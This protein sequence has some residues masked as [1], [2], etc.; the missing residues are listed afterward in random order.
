V[1]PTAAEPNE[2]PSYRALF[3]VPAIGRVLLGIVIARTAATMS[4]VVLVL[5]TLTYFRSP[6]LAGAVTFISIAPGLL[7]APLAGAL[8][9]RHGRARLVLVDYLVAA[10]ACVVIAVLAMAGTLTAPLLLL[11]AACNGLAW[12][13]STSG[14]RSLLPMLVP[15]PL[16]ERANAIDSNGYVIATLIGPPVAGAM[17]AV[18]GGPTA[19]AI[20]G[21]VYAA[22]AISMVGIPDPRTPFES[23]GRLL[24]DALDGLRYVARN[25]TLLALAASVS[26]WN[27][28]GGMLQI[29]VPV[30]LI[31][32]LGEGPAVVGLAWAT[33]GLAGLVAALF[34]GR[35]DSRGREKRMIIWPL[36]G[37]SVAMLLLLVHAQLWTIVIV[38]AFIGLFN[39]PMDVA[40]FTIRQRRTDPAWMGR[41]FAISMALNFAG[42][43]LGSAI[44][45]LL[46]TR[47]VELTV[48]IAAATALLAAI[49]AW[50]LIP[51]RD[52]PVPESIETLPDSERAPTT[53]EGDRGSG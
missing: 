42:F 3:A 1:I 37:T 31:D 23:S 33:S 21:L 4:S 6:E 38:L 25:R 28:G 36:I 11:I 30:L 9:D 16:W 43:P 19:I 8:L 7:I 51:E 20:V 26:L 12:P 47:S 34:V 45:G 27:V 44:G 13:L 29:L 53:L 14:L 48:V 46:V 39:G 49:A 15:K 5:F 40:M 22:A 2:A 17:V 35:I 24:V 52:E 32:R 50:R 18:A 10:G 41:A